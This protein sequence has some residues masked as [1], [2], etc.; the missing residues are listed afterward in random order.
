[1]DS[2]PASSTPSLPPKRNGYQP[3]K[4]TAF[5]KSVDD[6]VAEMKANPDPN[7]PPRPSRRGT[8]PEDFADLFKPAKERLAP[9]IQQ[10]RQD[11]EDGRMSQEQLAMCEG[12]Y[13]AQVKNEEMAMAMATT[14]QTASTVFITLN[15]P[16]RPP[17]DE[18][19]KQR[20]INEV[21]GVAKQMGY[22][23]LNVT[24]TPNSSVFQVDVSRK[25][26]KGKAFVGDGGFSA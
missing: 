1:M 18:D 10:C 23:V 3:G 13:E 2:A 14:Q 25:E 15:P 4:Y 7:P 21:S 9:W 16:R 24:L 12:S 22:D 20:L 8:T 26:R 11:M 17:Q 5:L 19:E 6:A